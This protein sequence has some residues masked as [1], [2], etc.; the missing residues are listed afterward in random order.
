MT[1]ELR[2]DLYECVFE[3]SLGGK[4]KCLLDKENSPQLWSG[5]RYEVFEMEPVELVEDSCLF[6]AKAVRIQ[7]PCHNATMVFE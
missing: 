3:D 2:E 5:D 4:K 1:Y 6:F 7:G